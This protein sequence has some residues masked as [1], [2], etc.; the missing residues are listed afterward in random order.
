MY[1]KYLQKTSEEAPI[2]KFKPLQIFKTEYNIDIHVP[3]KHKYGKSETFSNIKEK[4]EK[5]IASF[6]KHINV[7]DLRKIAFPLEQE[8]CK[9]ENTMLVASFDLEKVMSTPHGNSMLISFSR[10]YTV[11]NFTVYETERVEKDIIL[12]GGRKDGKKGAN[13]MC[14]NL[15]LYRKQVDEEGKFSTIFLYRDNCVG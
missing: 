12:H 11:Y 3:R 1:N 9:D 6:N 2:K 8:K 7:K 14:A 13:K 15:Y 5:N 4:T 10:R